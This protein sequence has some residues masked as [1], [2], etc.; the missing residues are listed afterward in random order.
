[1][2]LSSFIPTDIPQP[3]SQRW[4]PP[5]PACSSR[6][7]LGMVHTEVMMKTSQPPPP[8]NCPTNPSLDLSAT[9]DRKIACNADNDSL[10]PLHLP[11]HLLCGLHRLSIEKSTNNACRMLHIG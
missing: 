1:M 10:L 6:G 3:R 11:K 9:R 2:H 4:T 7:A 8:P 5:P